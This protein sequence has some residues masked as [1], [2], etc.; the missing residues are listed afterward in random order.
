MHDATM[1]HADELK[2][3]I[4][5]FL[6]TQDGFYANVAQISRHLSVNRNYLSGY[7]DGL[8]ACGALQKIGDKKAKFYLLTKIDEEK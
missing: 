6:K 5:D 7:L 2:Q 1:M 3:K 8:S 4:E